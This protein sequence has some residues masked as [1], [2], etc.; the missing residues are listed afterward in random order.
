MT[1]EMYETSAEGM[2]SILRGDN[3]DPFSIMGMHIGKDGIVIVRVFFPDATGVEV[4][5]RKTGKIVDALD[6]LH[7]D[8]FFA[9]RMGRRKKRFPYK[10]RVTLPDQELVM[11][12]PYR[13]YTIL[14]EKETQMLAEGRFWH[15]YNKLG[16]HITRHDGVPGVA[17]AV[18]APNASRVS[19]V[20]EFNNWDGRRHVMRLRHSCS[21]WELF[22]PDLTEGDNYMFEIKDR[23]GL[24]LPLKADPY[25][26]A[27]ELRPRK[28]SVIA[29]IDQFK[30][31]DKH[32]MKNRAKR[33]A[34]DAPISVYEVHLGSWSRVPEED[35]RSLN[36]RELADKLIPYV[37]DMGFTHIQLLPVSEFPF[38]GSW[39][40][41]PV[42]LFAPTSRFG[43]PEDFKYLVERCH[44]ENIGVLLDWVA[45]H[46]PADDHGLGRFDGSHLYEH[47]DPRRGYH[48]DWHTLI[49]NYGRF[50]VSNFLIS[51]ALFWL[52]RY[53]IDGLRADAVASMLYLD[54]SRQDDEW[55]PNA[56]GGNTNLEAIEFLR[57]LNELASD[58]EGA[59]IVAE[60]STS[61]PG[62]SRPTSKGGLGFDYKWNMGWMHDTLEYMKMDPVYRKHHHH[63]MT[64]GLVYAYSENF[65]LPLSHDE[66]VHMKGSLLTR[67][68][69]DDWQR[70]ANLRA[71]YGFMWSHPGKKL[72]FMGGEFAQIREWNFEASLDWHLLD[73]KFHKG[74][75]TLVRDLNHYYVNT[76]ALYQLDCEKSGFQWIKVDESEESYYA[77]VR[78]GRDNAHPVL[79]LCNFTPV[80]RYDLRLGVPKEGNWNIKID[81]D[82]LEYGG[83]GMIQVAGY[84]TESVPS[85]NQPC[86]VT[87][88]L[89]PLATM[90]LEWQQ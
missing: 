76:P 71:Y 28:N 75:Q 13:F 68:P 11:E 74:I 84:Q 30:W 79:V 16:A 64:F 62:V 85:D 2:K 69:G 57:C 82:K 10:L 39:G 23:N 46:F 77:W 56:Q 17:F 32:W 18:W 58:F 29:K 8:G 47:E 40:Y 6:L 41:Q 15:A 54:Y 7:E 60:E 88:D 24:L 43:K 22:I 3:G 66:V 38:D 48:P 72:L 27:A 20:G 26:F 52:D 34:L 19:V 65:I 61:W 1:V 21:I 83:S 63:K 78:M 42:S 73:N 45:A 55:L 51:N 87:V 36:Y 31:A 70:F 89:P 14:V 53:H 44:Q 5:D 9:G 81:T 67:M 4:I 37:K 50:E 86:S 35:N 33:N 80:P 12:D 25:A 59:T 49:Y 90:I